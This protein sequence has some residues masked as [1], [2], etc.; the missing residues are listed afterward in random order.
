MP[1]AQISSWELKASGRS[2]MKIMKKWRNK[3]RDIGDTFINAKNCGRSGNIHF[4]FDKKGKGK[5]CYDVGVL[6]EAGM[7]RQT[8][9]IAD[10]SLV[11]GVTSP[12]DWPKLCCCDAQRDISAV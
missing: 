8:N 2:C 10:S 3:D 4:A 7:P 6:T 9:D 5:G 12:E 11:R 1:S